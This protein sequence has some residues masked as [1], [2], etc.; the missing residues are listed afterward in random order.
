[1]NKIVL[2][3]SLLTSIMTA[4]AQ[5]RGGGFNQEEMVEREK[6]MVLTKFT[7]LSDDQKMLVEGIYEEFAVTL[8]ETVNEIRKSGDFSQFRVKMPALREEKDLLLKDVF[9]EQQYLEYTELMNS[10][11]FRLGRGQRPVDG[12]K[13]TSSDSTKVE[14]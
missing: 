1:M 12:N 7:D 9:N 13:N 11:P 6:E 3:F 2:T 14:Q 5:P 4:I 8:E 10:G